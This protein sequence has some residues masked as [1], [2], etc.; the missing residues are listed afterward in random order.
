MRIEGRTAI[1]TGAS[2]GIG[3]ETA[4]ELARRRA[5][6]VLASRTEERLEAIASELSD[7]PGRR[8]AVA[9]DVTDRL[10]VEALVRRTA[11]EF[12]AIDILVNN[13]GTGL[14]APIVEG[15]L[16]N[17]H[18]LFDVNFWGAVNCIQAAVPYMRSQ[19]RGH[20]VNVSSIAGRIAT[21]YLG[22]YSASKF[23]LGAV[24][25]ALRS[26]LAGTGVHVSTIFPGLT[27]TSFQQSMTREAEVPS[28][29]RGLR[30]APAEAVARRISQAVRWR[31][32]DV[33][34]SP[35]DAAAVGIHALAPQISDWGLR[36]L[37]LGGSM[38]NRIR[39][40][41]SPP[42]AASPQPSPADAEPPAEP[43]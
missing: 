26:E 18:R 23:A 13:A 2:S 1:V 43:A 21:P 41:L 29:P 19:E 40:S 10:A 5:N 8:V 33:Y 11:E 31:L 4:R 3:K 7:L 39:E 36:A 28:P 14:F 34:V 15:S 30:Y 20:V 16:E 25:D 12:G 32:R 38:P 6:V 9:V 24:S 27:E 22:I 35:E 17:M 42:T 37:W